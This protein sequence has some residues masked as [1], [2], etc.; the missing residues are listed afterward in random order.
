MSLI[1]TIISCVFGAVF[2]AAVY[3]TALYIYIKD[4]LVA[5]YCWYLWSCFFHIGALFFYND[6]LD[7]FTSVPVILADLFFHISV[8]VYAGYV[9][10]AF[11]LTKKAD[12]NL[13]RFYK[14]FVMINSLQGGVSFYVRL[15]VGQPN[16]LYWISMVVSNSFALLFVIYGFF[17]LLKLAKSRFLTLILLGV[18]INVLVT[19]ISILVLVLFRSQS[20]FLGTAIYFVGVFIDVAIFSIA[21]GYKF[22]E[23]MDE[24]LYATSRA[25]EYQLAAYKAEVQK[26]YE[27]LMGREKERKE[28]SLDLHDHLANDIAAIKVRIEKEIMM[29]S[30]NSEGLQQINKMITDVYTNI[31]NK[32]HDWF[33]SGKNKISILFSEEIKSLLHNGLPDRC[34]SIV[35]VDDSSIDEITNNAK[36][37]LLII[38]REAVLNIKKHAKASKVQV[39]VYKEVAG[40]VLQIIDD[41]I[42]FE[43]LQKSDGIGL[44]S[45]KHRME[46]LSGDVNITSGQHGTTLLITLPIK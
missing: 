14:L 4:R 21:M 40:L 33:G 38:I 12:K 7:S 34:E 24:K 1:D 19:L 6:S 26:E 31:R 39:L 5:W 16:M 44:Q 22:K 25:A 8:I 23:S 17:F 32:S 36:S 20:P 30:E 9:I 13:W 37:E 28:L 11:G 15:D 2:L 35:M 46:G 43:L 29:A 41:G 3:H 42:G 27:V 10:S 45:I 18:V